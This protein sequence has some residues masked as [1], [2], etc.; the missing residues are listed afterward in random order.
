[1]E[2]ESKNK[3]LISEVTRIWYYVGGFAFGYLF[4]RYIRIRKD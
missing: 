3:K 2:D 4:G 1:M